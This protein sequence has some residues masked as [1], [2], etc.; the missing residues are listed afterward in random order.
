MQADL[1]CMREML[2]RDKKWKFFLGP[3]ATEMPLVTIDEMEE[4]L[5]SIGKSVI[6]A[7]NVPTADHYR[8]ITEPIAIR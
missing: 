3:A 1:M 4:R 8:F 7:Y 2:R 5:R 6:E